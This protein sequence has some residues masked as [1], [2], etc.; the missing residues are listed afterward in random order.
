TDLSDFLVA[1]GMVQRLDDRWELRASLEAV[2]TAAPDTLRH[3]IEAH[4]ARLQSDERVALEAASV[5]GVD[6]PASVVAAGLE[7]SD[8]AAETCL[9]GLASRGQFVASTGLAAAPGH[10]WSSGYQFVH[11]LH[12]E[13]LYRALP[14]ARRLR[15]HRRVAE[16][17]ER[18][19]GARADQAASELAEHFE[20]A[21]EYPRA[22]KYLRLAAANETR[23]FANREA[24]LWLDSALRIAPEL[25]AAE[26]VGARIAVLNDLG[27]VRRSMGDMRGSS[28]PFQEAARAA[29][30]AGDYASTVEALLLA[31]SA[32]TWVDHD[33]CLAA[34]HEAE[35]LA[36][37][38]GPP[39]TTYVRGYSAHWYP[40]WDR[41]DDAQAD[42]CERALALARESRDPLRL[43]S[44]LPRCAYVRLA[45]GK[46][47]E[48]AAAAQQGGEQALAADDA[49][50]RMV[51]QFFEAWA[52]ILAGR[53]GHTDLLL[54]HSLHLAERNGHRSWQVLFSGLRAWLLREA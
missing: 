50:G 13:V 24:V 23:R 33:A 47:A 39:L 6:F 45:R 16:R 25:P 7:I 20:Q 32:L 22:I 4:L 43:F 15:L 1:K 49:F 8:E 21:R 38:L 10:G 36:Q 40:L 18:E 27:R 11:A 29:S 19:F 12:Q 14:P 44:M 28:E 54:A 51:C 3:L 35:R 30:T 17:I 5:C 41:W 53:W 48:A 42:D 52:E 34:A 31:A 26:S 9:D 46:Y 37:I 2:A